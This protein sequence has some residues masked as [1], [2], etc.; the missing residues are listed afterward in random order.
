MKAIP[1]EIEADHVLQSEETM[2]SSDSYLPVTQ[3]FGENYGCIDTCVNMGLLV[4]LYILHAQEKAYWHFTNKH[5]R[6]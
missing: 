2:K 5:E 6:K 4:F 1:L 3:C